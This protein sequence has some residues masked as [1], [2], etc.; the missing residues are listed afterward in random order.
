MSKLAL[1]FF[2]ANLTASAAI[3]PP[4]VHLANTNCKGES[5]CIDDFRN[6]EIES[7]AQFQKNNPQMQDSDFFVHECIKQNMGTQEACTQRY[8]SNHLRPPKDNQN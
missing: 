5:A 3:P 6:K 7:F 8:K 2:M 1:L 4:W